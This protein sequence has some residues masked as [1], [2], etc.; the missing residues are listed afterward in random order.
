MVI[1]RT[2]LILLALGVLAGCADEPDGD[3]VLEFWAMGAEGEK[4]QPL[5]DRFEAEHP[6]IRVEVQQQP[7]TSVH[8]KLLTAFAGRSTPDVSQFGNT[9]VAEME[10]LGALE[11]LTPYVRR[12]AGVDEGDYFPGVWDTN[13][14]DGRLWGVPWYV[15]TRLLFY[16]TDLFAQA[17]Y[18]E[19]PATW[20]GWV[21]AM[22]AVQAVQPEGGYPLL[23]PVN[24]FEPPLILGLNTADL[25]RDGDRYGNFRSDG[26][27]RAFGFY[28]D[29]YREGLAPATS[30][31]EISNLYQEIDRGRFA[32]LITGPWN[33]GEF[34][35]RLTEHPDDWG[36]APIP[37]PE[38][39]TP[40]LSVAGG[41]SLVIFER[42]PHKA[43]AW[44]LVEFLSRPDVQAEFNRLTGNLPPRTSVWE[45][46]GLA[47]DRYARAFFEQLG[48]VRP[49][50]KV[51]EQER[52]AQAI[53]EVGEFA[54][55]GE[56]TVDQ[57]VVALDADVDRILEKRRWLL[58]REGRGESGS[59]GG[60]GMG[61]DGPGASVRTPIPSHSRTQ[62][63]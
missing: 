30:G 26:F 61:A 3:V 18:D 56:L 43:E 48:H 28:I 47:D 55:R 34:Q 41:A 14:I 45:T 39:G 12:S 20:D 60:R 57:A 46:T 21:E 7:W 44:A 49:T 10:A 42:S 40:G 51:P 50:P 33:I 63:L 29:L 19:M 37:G 1:L 4:V 23:M 6:G 54:A 25:L 13:V 15:D 58:S 52:I 32:S 11:D 9:W 22:R 53:R 5:I 62:P 8:E 2:T 38:P 36:T 35:R 27:R 16:R 59:V 17:G 24:E 31:T